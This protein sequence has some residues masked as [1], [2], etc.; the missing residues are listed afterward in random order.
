MADKR[1]DATGLRQTT[2]NNHGNPWLIT[3]DARRTRV[4]RVG[5]PQERKCVHRG[6]VG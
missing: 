3:K 1:A 4:G 6:S 2:G 5:P